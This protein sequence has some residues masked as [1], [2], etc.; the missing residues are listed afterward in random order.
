MSLFKT[1]KQWCTG[2]FYAILR[3]INRKSAIA[4]T[5][6]PRGGYRY[7]VYCHGIPISGKNTISLDILTEFFMTYVFSS[8]SKKPTEQHIHDDDVRTY[9]NNKQQ[10]NNTEHT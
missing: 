6:K 2:G 1:A 9:H 8:C 3:Y 7:T 5:I 10:A 4:G